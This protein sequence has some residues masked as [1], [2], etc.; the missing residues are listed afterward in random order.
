MW[1]YKEVFRGLLGKIENF[2]KTLIGI[3]TVL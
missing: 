2:M 3:T 1:D